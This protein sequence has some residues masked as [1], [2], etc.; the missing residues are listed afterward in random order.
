VRGSPFLNKLNSWLDKINLKMKTEYKF[1]ILEKTTQAYGWWYGKGNKRIEFLWSKKNNKKQSSRLL[2]FLHGHGSSAIRSLGFSLVGIRS[3]CDVLSISLPGY[4]YSDGPADYCGPRSVE[5]IT[6]FLIVFLKHYSYTKKFLWGISR[7]AI[8]A[9]LLA[10]K[11]PK[12]F[13]GIILQAGA[14]DFDRFYKKIQD[15][16][17]K[18]NIRKE[19]GISVKAFKERSSLKTLDRYVGPLLILYGKQDQADSMQARLL[20]ERRKR[21]GLPVMIKTYPNEFHRIPLAKIEPAIKKFV[22]KSG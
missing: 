1:R 11:A 21:A 2:V 13:D 7:G 5:R 15:S 19:A 20:Y 10:S 17:L 22:E 9:G 3:G 14:Y 12:L 4:G 8:T 16:I 6:S 18:N